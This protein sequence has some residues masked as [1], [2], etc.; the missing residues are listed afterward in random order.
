MTMQLA[1]VNSP[2]AF[3]QSDDQNRCILREETTLYV[4]KDQPMRRLLSVFYVCALFSCRPAMAQDAKQ[5]EIK[6]DPVGYWAE[7]LTSP[8]RK[9]RGSAVSALIALGPKAKPVVPALIDVLHNDKDKYLRR[10]AATAFGRIGPAAKAAVPALAEALQAE[11]YDLVSAAARSLGEIGPDARDA[12]PALS[13]ALQSRYTGVVYNV[14]FALGAIGPAAKPAEPMLLAHLAS[15]TPYIRATAAEALWRIDRHPA[16]IPELVKH[17]QDPQSTD[18][19]EAAEA[20]GRIGPDAKVAVPALL[21]ALKDRQHLTPV[22]AAEALWFVAK[23]ELAIPMLT[24]ALKDP[25][26][27][28]RC[29]AAYWLGRIGPAA[30]AAVPALVEALRDAGLYGASSTAA[31]ALKSIDPE[32]ARQAGAR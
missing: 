16:A 22:R 15:V 5:S 20:L 13:V 25:D 24:G 11:D 12:V 31:D 7:R 17:L 1:P 9:T 4:I 6:R 27:T 8:D 28:T 3:P 14:A 32:A 21:A 18:R 23:H 29:H 19:G 30:K 2:L 26:P 10:G